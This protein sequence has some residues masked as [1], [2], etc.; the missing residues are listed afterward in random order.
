MDL[1]NDFIWGTLVVLGLVALM[2]V[3]NYKSSDWK[4]VERQEGTAAPIWIMIFSLALLGL[5]MAIVAERLTILV[6]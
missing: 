6:K 4:A 1:S 2:L 3:M 5:L